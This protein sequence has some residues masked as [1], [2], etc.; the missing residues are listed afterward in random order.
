MHKPPYGKIE[1]CLT[2]N[3]QPPQTKY[4][5]K[6]KQ[7]GSLISFCEAAPLLDFADI[8]YIRTRGALERFDSADHLGIKVLIFTRLY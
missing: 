2:N 1:T 6:L 4:F 5:N 7:C 3:T 8:Q